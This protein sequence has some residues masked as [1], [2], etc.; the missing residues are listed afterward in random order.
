MFIPIESGFALT[1]QN[2][3][4]LFETAWSKKIVLVSPSTL[5]ATLRTIA[6]VWKAE[7]SNKNTQEIARQAGEMYDK[8]V[9]FAESLNEVGASIAKAEVKYHEAVNR[10]ST[11]KGN[12]VKR[13]ESLRKLGIKTTKNL[14][15]NMIP[16]AEE[17]DMEGELPASI[18][19]D[20]P[21]A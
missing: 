21:E 16:D 8:F 20:E 1:M 3:K 13:A 14:P 15:A 10:L 6:S 5:L 4:E 19:T 11:G 17:I 18:E 2:D 9:G 7:K 12:L